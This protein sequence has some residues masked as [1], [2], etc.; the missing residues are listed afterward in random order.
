[1]Q[2]KVKAPCPSGKVKYLDFSTAIAK[3]EIHS[4]DEVKLYVYLCKECLF[5]HHTRTKVVYTPKLRRAWER[6]LGIID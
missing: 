6:R 1:M 4:R 5:Y 3:A 2:A